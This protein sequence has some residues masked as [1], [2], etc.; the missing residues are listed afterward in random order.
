MDR[1]CRLL[2]LIGLICVCVQKVYS[3]HPSCGTDIYRNHVEAQWPFLKAYQETLELRRLVHTA[4]PA[5]KPGEKSGFSPY[6]IPVVVHVIH[7]NGAEN[8]PDAQIQHGIDQLNASF[9]NTGYYDQGNGFATPIAFCLA[10]QTPDGLFTNG[11]NRLVSP[12]TNMAMES[13]DLDLKNIIRW[14]PGEYLNIWVVRE[15]NSVSFGS[16]VAGYAYFPSSHGSPIDGIVIE[17]AF[18]GSTDADNTVLTHEA[19]HYLGLF[20]T[21]EGGCVNNDCAVDGDRVCDTPPDASQASLPC[22][23]PF[24][25][26]TTD[27]SSGFST[28]QPDMIINYMDYGGTK[29]LNAFTAG[30]SDRM[31]YFLTDARASLLTSK[32]CLNP[33]TVPVT[34]LFSPL[35]GASVAI[36]SN[37]QFTVPNQGPITYNWTVN[38]VPFGNNPTAAY[39]FVMPGEYIIQLYVQG[40]DPNCFDT[41]TDTLTVF[42]GVEANFTVTPAEPFIGDAVAFTNTSTGTPDI[43]WFVQGQAEGSANALSKTFTTPGTYTAC[44]IAELPFCNDTL[45]KS[46]EVYDTITPLEVCDNLFDDDG[47]GLTDCLDTLDCPCNVPAPYCSTPVETNPPKVFGAVEW[48]S[49]QNNIDAYSVPIVGNLNPLQDDIPEILV[50]NFDY[51][52]AKNS[53]IIIFSGDGSNASNPAVLNPGESAGYDTYGRMA[54]G[55][56]DGNGIPELV[57]LYDSVLRVYTNYDPTANPPMQLWMESNQV[58]QSFRI[59]PFLADLDED[60]ISEIVLGTRVYYIDLSNPGLPALRMVKPFGTFEPDNV[61][62][63]AEMLTPFD[64]FG[65]PDCEGLELVRGNII[66]TVDL[67]DTPED[68][69]PREVYPRVNVSNVPGGSSLGNGGSTVAD[70]D[71]DGRLD[72]VTRVSGSGNVTSYVYCWNPQK[73]I[74]RIDYAGFGKLD[75]GSV[76]SVANIFDDTKM[77]AATD[78]PE[79]LYGSDFRMYCLNL[80]AAEMNPG[81]PFWWSVPAND[82]NNFSNPATI[83]DFDGDGHSEVVFR[84]QDS[85]TVIYGDAPPFP[86]GVQPDRIWFRHYAFGGTNEE[87]Q[88]IA[89]VDNDGQAEILICGDTDPT[90]FGNNYQLMVIGADLSKTTPW[91]GAR[92]LWNQ[93]NYLPH[94]VN[95]DLSIPKIIPKAHLQMPPGSGRRPGNVALAQKPLV[96][97]YNGYRYLPNGV[98]S[99]QKTQCS[100]QA[101]TATV[102]ICNTGTEILPENTPLRVYLGN[103]ADPTATLLPQ[104]FSTDK[105]LFPDSCSNLFLTLPKTAGQ[106]IFIVLNDDGSHVPPINP[107]VDFLQ[108]AIAECDYSDNV[109]DFEIS[110]PPAPPNLG[111]DTS[112]CANGVWNLNAGSGFES[113]RW[114]TLA[115]D[116]AVT[117][118]TPGQYWVEAIDQC[119]VTYTD[120]VLIRFRPAPEVELGADKTICQDSS[121]QLAVFDSF[122]VYSWH[123]ASTLSCA[124]CPNPVANPPQSS[125]YFLTVRDALGCLGF[126]TLRVQVL[127]TAETASNI[128]IC[129]GDSV[130]L[131]GQYAH[132][133]GTYTGMFQSVNGCDSTHQ[134]TLTVLPDVETEESLSICAGDSVLLFGQYAHVGGTYT[135][136]FPSVNGCDSTH[137]VTLTVLPDVETEESLSI[138]AGDSVLLFGQYA[139]VGGTYTGMFPSVNGCDSTHQVTLTVLPDV[140]TAE[141]LSICAGDSVL[142]FGQYAHVGGTYTGM[143]PSVIGCDSTHQVTLTV[144]PDVETAESLSICVG[145]SVLL[146][147]Q[148]AH[149]TG[150]Y[151]GAFQSLTG[152][153]STHV[154]QL[155]V[156]PTI[157]T[158]E[159]KQV[160]AGDSILIFDQYENQAGEFSRSFTAIG[161]CDSTH[162]ITLQVVPTWDTQESKQICIGDSVLIFGVVQTQA[163]VYQAVFS[164]TGGCDSIHTVFLDVLPVLQ[165]T[166]SLEICPGDSVWIFDQFETAAGVYQQTYSAAGGCDSLARIYL[167]VI[168]PPAVTVTWAAPTCLGDTN[169]V[170]R[171]L[172]NVL[173]LTFSLD[174]GGFVSELVFEGLGAGQHMLVGQDPL[175]CTFPFPFEI[176]APEPF[177]VALPAD[178]LVVAGQAIVLTPVVT[179]TGT[180]WNWL[181]GT[182]LNCPV[183]PSVVAAPLEDTRYTLVAANGSGCVA[184][185]DI[186]VQVQRIPSP[187]F[188]VPNVFAPDGASSDQYFTVFG[189]A[190]VA[191]V[192]L[193]EVYDRWGS[194]LFR[195]AH[196]PA[197]VDALGW[198]GRYKGELAL[199][200]TYVYVVEVELVDGHRLRASGSVTLV[201]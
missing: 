166:E 103:P 132:V 76:L 130:L 81:Q 139:H 41:Q 57:A 140:E 112:V 29:C 182:G 72:V 111:S 68:G 172:T 3:Q 125:T 116:S 18:L 36:G 176:P 190:D 126:D 184:S 129:E 97:V 38:G 87:Y 15:V 82:P 14:N 150:T 168:Q 62:C 12:L 96:S 80:H 31:V 128:S 137:Q 11:I 122:L 67:K 178:T 69:D 201:R 59:W 119:G 193:L 152:C 161:A 86:A 114:S 46:F 180:K 54:V 25:S 146:F 136:M 127:N 9:A 105:A 2:L 153:D 5:G 147:G 85:L 8:I 37:V 169:G 167:S 174:G 175:G 99:M 24:N 151:S 171:V 89:D 19:G 43:Q 16:G 45:C 52:A 106:K 20:H 197:G 155:F 108:T 92:K 58:P 13:Q 60:G 34:A 177:G 120:T 124:D 33:C 32:G 17:A 74:K 117:A 73:F 121:L 28:D 191:E 157:M 94:Y 110:L 42:C 101:V 148:Y 123:P 118:Y 179:G 183:C 158:S 77:G 51:F 194:M 141:S 98:M 90:M 187:D 145:D 104:T 149:L 156:S 163:G 195:R 154:I 113:Y 189:S 66:Y 78:L 196:F 70:V 35:N 131:F 143:F 64:C 48:A 50:F 56:L 173:G 63:A 160:C 135:G 27:V 71:L 164:T 53:K 95:D 186:L 200:G 93:Y 198:D 30:Q 55:D 159:T 144:L 47:D 39:T 61:T 181:P 107:P 142:L 4:K 185:D 162:T 102:N 83:F 91:K 6:T 26:C 65:D 44:L 199:P 170:V 79:I 188:F 40:A 109:V 21:F 134:V 23:A 10:K 115:T 7:Q 100:G 22:D 192:V 84:W 165:S 138:C 75:V 133:G 49:P 88:T 1:Y